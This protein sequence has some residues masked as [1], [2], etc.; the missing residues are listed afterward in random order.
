MKVHITPE[1]VSEAAMLKINCGL[2]NFYAAELCPVAEAINVAMYANGWRN[3]Y[4]TVAFGVV[5]FH[6]LDNSRTAKHTLPDEVARVERLFD[7]QDYAHIT[8]VL[9]VINMLDVLLR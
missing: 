4:A 5:T 9:F 2:Y 8:P 6:S 7:A 1:I 3:I